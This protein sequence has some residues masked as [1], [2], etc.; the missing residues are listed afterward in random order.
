MWTQFYSDMGMEEEYYVGQTL[1]PEVGYQACL[2]LG[3]GDCFYNV[4]YELMRMEGLFGKASSDT[5]PH[6]QKV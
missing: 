1:G 6:I 5:Q 2:I 4:L 3:M